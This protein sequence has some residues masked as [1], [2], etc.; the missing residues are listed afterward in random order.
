[1]RRLVAG[2]AVALVVLAG[3]SGDDGGSGADTTPAGG[4]GAG[5]VDVVLTTPALAQ[6]SIGGQGNLAVTGVAAD[7]FVAE[8]AGQGNLTASGTANSLTAVLGGAGDLGL[9]ELQAKRIEI[10]LIGKG[11]I[12]VWA[13]E[14]LNVNIIGN[15]NVVYKGDPT[16]EQVIQG[17]GTVQKAS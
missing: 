8:I 7:R 17:S 6:A 11:N 5:K 9:S 16:V 13:T 4:S 10:Q 14:Y 12:G 3:C 2:V 1:M 15:G